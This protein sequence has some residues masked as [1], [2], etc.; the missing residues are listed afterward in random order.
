MMSAIRA[1]LLSIGNPGRPRPGEA[2]V[3]VGRDRALHLL[4]DKGTDTKL[5]AAG[6]GLS[7][8]VGV[9]DGGTGASTATAGFDNLAPTTTKGDLIAYD[10]SD[11]VRLPAGTAGQVLTAD[12]TATTGLRWASL[13]LAVRVYASDG[14]ADSE[15]V[16]L[17]NDNPLVTTGAVTAAP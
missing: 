7:S 15:S 2:L 6:G 9:A 1:L 13:A 10:G 8:P 11:N 12:S 16:I 14:L 5:G 17:P 3:Y 4:D